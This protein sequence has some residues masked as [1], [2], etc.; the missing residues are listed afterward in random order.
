MMKF[1]IVEKRKQF[2]FLLF[3]KSNDILF[4]VGS[5]KD[6]CIMKQNKQNECYCNQ[7]G[8]HYSSFK[9]VLVGKDFDKGEQFVVKRICVYQMK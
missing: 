8:F 1:P 6:I 9:N 7:A 2:A 4:S 3:D 5:G